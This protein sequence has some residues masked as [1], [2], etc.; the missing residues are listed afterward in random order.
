MQFFFV[1]GGQQAKGTVQ[2]YFFFRFS[3]KLLLLVSSIMHRSDFKILS[4]KYSWSYLNS[5]FQKRTIFLGN[6]MIRVQNLFVSV[7]THAASVIAA[8]IHFC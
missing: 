4:L 8:I 1:G 5:K 6:L 7:Y 3:I 2:R